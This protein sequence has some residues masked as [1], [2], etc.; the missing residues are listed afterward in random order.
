MMGEKNNNIKNLIIMTERNLERGLIDAINREEIEV[1][2]QA[3]ISLI[4][5]TICGFE[6]LARWEFDGQAISPLKFIPLAEEKG[7]IVELGYLVL[8]KAC[9][10][11]KELHELGYANLKIAV[12]VSV[13]QLYDPLFIEKVVEILMLYRIPVHCIELEITESLSIDRTIIGEKLRTLQKMG[14]QLVM[15]DFGTGFAS[16]E[17]LKENY[18]KKVKVDKI[19]LKELD[20]FNNQNKLFLQSIINLLI[21]IDR[22]VLV[23]GVETLEQLNFLKEI[24]CQYVQGFLFSIP[25]NGE[26]TIQL[27]KDWKV[28]LAI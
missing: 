25:A 11:L 3:Q 21:G 13:K 15:D 18:F 27:L 7:L 24:N 12:N 9:Q 28:N 10:F 22:E 8:E 26:K 23:E 1:H 19:F 6:A 16:L 5:H 4:D 14:I 20:S 2:Y 17:Y